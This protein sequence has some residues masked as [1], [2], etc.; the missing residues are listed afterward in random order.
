MAESRGLGDV[1]KRQVKDLS[2]DFTYDKTYSLADEDSYLILNGNTVLEVDG[3]I[4]DEKVT[5]DIEKIL[6]AK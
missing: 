4:Y 2:K 1:Y 6:E 5:K 3:N